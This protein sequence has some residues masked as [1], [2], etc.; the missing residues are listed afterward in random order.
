MSFPHCP[1]LLCNTSPFF[2]SL[3]PSPVPYF[4]CLRR[5]SAVR[6]HP[7]T[8]VAHPCASTLIVISISDQHSDV[9]LDNTAYA[10]P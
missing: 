8:G 3:F 9:S 2:P 1:P 7:P 6:L 4:C 5:N 10:Y